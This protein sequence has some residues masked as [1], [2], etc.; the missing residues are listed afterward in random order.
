MTLGFQTR[1]I[2]ST[3]Q[4]RRHQIY[5]G[6]RKILYDGPE[7]GTYVLYFKDEIDSLKGNA[8]EEG[9]ENFQ[10]EREM[11]SGKGV[12]NSRISELLMTRLSEIGVVTQFL[13]RLNM[14]EQLVRM[15]EPL[16]FQVTL[17]NTMTKAFAA[18]L[19]VSEDQ[20]LLQP[21]AEFSVRIPGKRTSSV[22]AAEHIKALGWAREDEIDDMLTVIQRVNDFLFG[23][24]SGLGVR[25]LNFTLE[26]GRVYL[27]EY[28]DESHLVI[29]DE[30]SPDT[31]ELTDIKTQEPL[32]RR[33]FDEKL[34]MWE[35][36]Y[37]E[38]ARRLGL[39]T[40]SDPLPVEYSKLQT[41]QDV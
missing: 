35:Y 18:R 22:I 3:L 20:P 14:R 30:M 12:L 10:A 19:G 41:I 38:I 16:P 32:D 27:S 39:L 34:P 17:H 13:R 6:S 11:I 26:F 7:A 8:S 31:C 23:Q 37:Q 40:E 15:A 24:F 25:L 29:I 28:M 1:P 36:G 4:P 2:A 5:E 21:I 9:R 33:R